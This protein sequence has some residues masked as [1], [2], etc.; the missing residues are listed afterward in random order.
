MAAGGDKASAGDAMRDIGV[1]T[2]VK[3]GPKAMTS[4]G[5]AKNNVKRNPHQGGH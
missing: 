1:G 4:G 2:N 3:K 5:V